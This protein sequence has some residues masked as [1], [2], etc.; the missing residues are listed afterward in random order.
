MT[1]FD[2]TKDSFIKAIG[3]E[4]KDAVQL[5]INLANMSKH[6]VMT[7]CKQSE[8]CEEIA[9]TFSYNELLLIATLFVTEKTADIMEKNP[10]LGAIS[11]LHK[12]LSELKD[13][14]EKEE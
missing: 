9:K 7:Q 2:H 4:E 12:L 14:N 6:I 5:N 3:F 10:S 8:L 1:T 13:E 11:H